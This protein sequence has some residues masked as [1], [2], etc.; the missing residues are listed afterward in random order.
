MHMHMHMHM[1]MRSDLTAGF[2]SLRCSART[3]PRPHT[4]L[5][6]QQAADKS[7]SFLGDLLSLSQP[8]EHGAKLSQRGRPRVILGK[9]RSAT[10]N[11]A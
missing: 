7:S 6:A 11:A 10:S 2:D 9:S 4:Q 1:Q 8:A 3:P 5:R